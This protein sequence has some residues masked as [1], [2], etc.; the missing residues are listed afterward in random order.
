[1]IR[2]WPFSGSEKKQ[3]EEA[4][5]VSTEGSGVACPHPVAYQIPIRD[6]HQPNDPNAVVGVKCAQCGKKL[7]VV[8]AET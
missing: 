3:Q 8:Q 6:P 7:D 2:L 1:M 4:N 5:A